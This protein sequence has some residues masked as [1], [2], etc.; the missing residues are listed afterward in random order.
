[1]KAKA[2]TLIELLVACHPK[3]GAR[4]TERRTIRAA[5]TLIELLVVIAIIAILAALLL[6][7]LENAREAARRAACVSNMRQLG[8]YTSMYSSDFNDFVPDCFDGRV[9]DPVA[10]TFSPAGFNVWN[11]IYTAWWV[12]TPQWVGAG[13]LFSGG[14]MT[15]P[16]S[17]YC[18]GRTQQY[19]YGSS[20][21][22]WDGMQRLDACTASSYDQRNP[23][24][25]RD[26]YY[27]GVRMEPDPSKRGKHA[28]LAQSELV[29]MAD[30]LI[31][32]G[33]DSTYPPSH[34]GGINVL[35]Y[36]GDVIWH[37]EPL[38]DDA[39]HNGVPLNGFEWWFGIQPYFPGVGWSV[40]AY[41]T[42]KLEP[43]WQG[44]SI[45]LVGP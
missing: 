15:T 4:A 2:F 38:L 13:R 17:F 40:N 35:H 9:P 7:A 16:Q 31:V 43:W 23:Y 22:R 42:G 20:Y 27:T 3:L 25:F 34:R 12:T 30:Y 18:L 1:V 5:F 32:T 14:Y 36:N 10:G 26:V 11:Y 45:V 6:P 24:A 33:L 37:S 21:C 41:W 28:A 44:K 39:Y 8:L 19:T 29:A